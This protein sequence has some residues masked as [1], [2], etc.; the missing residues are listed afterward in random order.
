MNFKHWQYVF[1]YNTKTHSLQIEN[2]RE[3]KRE[4]LMNYSFI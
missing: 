2:L 4:S 1:D 3:L